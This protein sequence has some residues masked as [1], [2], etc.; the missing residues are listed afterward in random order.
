[1]LDEQ[2]DQVLA[3]QPAPHDGTDFLEDYRQLLQLWQY[4]QVDS[5]N[6]LV[7]RAKDLQALHA[8]L[9]TA[10]PSEPF[11]CVAK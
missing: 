9:E 10:G 4:Q 5:T 1:M 8:R 6:R 11:S 2:H 7:Q 3:D